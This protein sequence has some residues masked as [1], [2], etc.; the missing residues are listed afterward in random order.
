MKLLNKSMS[1]RLAMI[2]LDWIRNKDP[3]ISLG[4]ASVLAKLLED[5]K[6]SEDHAISIERYEYDVK[7][8]FKL[9]DNSKSQKDVFEDFCFEVSKNAFSTSPDMISI[10]AFVWNEIH[11]QRILNILRKDFNY[12]N[13]I[14]LGGPQVSYALPSTLET[15]Y[16]HADF[17]IRGYA[18]DS[19]NKLLNNQAAAKQN[20][21]SISPSTLI[22]G[23]HSHGEP[24]L[25][26]QS[27]AFL[28]NL[29]SPFLNSIIT[30]N[31]S[32]IRWESQRGCPFRCTFC[33]HR[34]SYSNRQNICSS[35]IERE[36]EMICDMNKSLVNDIAVLDPT[37]NSGNNY[38]SVLENFIRFNY[39]GKLS[40]QTRLE[41]VNDLFLE[42]I[43]LLKSQG[44]RVVL[45]CGIQTIIPDE[46]KVI[47]RPNNLKKIES[48]V[49]KLHER[50]IEFEI[51]VIFG[52]PMQTLDTFK[53]T[54]Y[55]CNEVL[56]PKRVDAFPL[57]ILRG[58]ELEKCRLQYGIVEEMIPANEF[59]LTKDRISEGIPHVTSSLSFT[60]NDWLK[61]YE[62]AQSL[63]C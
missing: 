26:L 40:L 2:S 46:M 17:F 9:N 62:I 24:D 45:E 35:R 39:K 50:N 15:F 19:F 53:R 6:V 57:M 52:L 36:I 55:Y 33:Q 41:M 13:K 20:R 59:Q 25:G 44:A 12:K 16:P 11:V 34:D 38:I 22:S 47:K 7:S 23:V 51:S 60:K 37:F 49:K 63:N 31:R 48:V 28:E 5:R 32:F 29:P 1:Y 21:K 43:S 8:S 10:G 61:M 42:K 4:H 58:T 18:E 54:V 30:L 14:C 27:K 3:K 56:K